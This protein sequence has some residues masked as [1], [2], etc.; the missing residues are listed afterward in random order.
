MR[1][2]SVYKEVR[3]NVGRGVFQRNIRELYS[4]YEAGALQLELTSMQ[5][6]FFGLAR[7]GLY[8]N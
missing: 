1:W 6:V 7:K 2:H 3:R 5:N 8:R 4:T